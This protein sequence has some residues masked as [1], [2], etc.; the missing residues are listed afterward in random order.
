MTRSSFE[1]AVTS[2]FNWK[3]GRF[4]NTTFN[5]SE[6]GVS[7]FAG[8]EIFSGL[9]TESSLNFG[10]GSAFGFSKDGGGL[11]AIFGRSGVNGKGVGTGGPLEAGTLSDADT[12]VPFGE[13]SKGIV[14]PLGLGRFGVG[15]SFFD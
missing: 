7:S 11:N 13:R 2:P 15:G 12:P 4:S 3:T 9:V 1:T 5:E 14:G 10:G 6:I 8:T